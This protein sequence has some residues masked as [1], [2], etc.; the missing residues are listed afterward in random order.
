V[1][2]QAIRS[3]RLHGFVQNEAFAHEVAARFYSTHGFEIIDHAY[4]RNVRNCYDHCGAFG[5]VKQHD[6]RR[7]HLGENQLTHF[8]LPSARPWRSWTS[9]P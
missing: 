1:F 9:R 8:R 4:L 5:K 3:A 2:S 6:E 7:R